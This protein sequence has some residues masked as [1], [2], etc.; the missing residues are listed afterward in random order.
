MRDS[1]ENHR[2][3]VEE[4][5]ESNVILTE[6]NPSIHGT[7]EKDSQLSEEE[8]LILEY[9]SDA[10]SNPQISAKELQ[11]LRDTFNS[12]KNQPESKFFVDLLSKKF[13]QLLNVQSAQTDPAEKLREALNSLLL[14]QDKLNVEDF[15]LIHQAKWENIQ[16][17]MI[18]WETQRESKQL[19]SGLFKVILPNIMSRLTS[20]EDFGS[21]CHHEIFT[22]KKDSPIYALSPKILLILLLE[23]FSEL[24][25]KFISLYSKIPGN[26]LPFLYF[27]D[28]ENAKIP[29]KSYFLLLSTYRPT[30][31]SL[32]PGNIGKSSL[33]NKIFF[34][35]FYEHTEELAHLGVD[36]VFSSD[37]FQLG[38][39]VYDFQ[40]SFELYEKFYS[41][42][43]HILPKD[44]WI[45]V[46]IP[47]LGEEG[48]NLVQK[49]LSDNFKYQPQNIIIIIR[50]TDE[51]KDPKLLL[52]LKIK[53][54]KL[55]IP[56][57]NLL[58]I[59][60]IQ[61]SSIFAS[62]L[63]ILR[64]SIL[65]LIP[66]NQKDGKT[67]SKNNYWFYEDR[68]NASNTSGNHVAVGVHS[69][70]FRDFSMGI[71]NEI[72]NESGQ[73]DIHQSLFRVMAV[74]KR[75]DHFSEKNNNISE[76]LTNSERAKE[77]D[78]NLKC[79]QEARLDYEKVK[80]HQLALNYHELILQKNDFKRFEF[81]NCLI[82]WQ[83]PLVA[84]FFEKR[85]QIK[86]KK[87]KLEIILER[88]YANR[89]ELQ[90]RQKE[91]APS[92]ELKKVEIELLT[93][94]QKEKIQEESNALSKDF[95]EVSDKL[96]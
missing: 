6:E 88:D 57:E 21:L 96:D 76:N 84:P 79:M 3:P 7:Y 70:D 60:K 9:I 63:K 13:P 43:L 23:R 34:T 4:T 38:Y 71:Q 56:K 33:T 14:E 83:E 74:K 41:R 72:N 2:Y 55:K 19:Q 35:Q 28:T 92:E 47:A 78:K 54:S 26:S 62:N 95:K 66:N 22:T 77:L 27:K 87:L 61:N 42:V 51:I 80:P 32:G 58:Q 75:I 15:S 24:S 45:L 89:E 50:D 31:I 36:A 93:S 5:K 30:I 67:I 52:S 86:E 10:L 90:N 49:L 40:G 73:D 68:Y 65:K 82:K 1:S 25:Y 29:L 12:Y 48:L 69:D 53:L 44:S 91:G 8:T 37:Q 17:A 85:N 59:P 18:D 39:N 94:E 16:K 11:E 81:E 64:E 20:A 46:Q